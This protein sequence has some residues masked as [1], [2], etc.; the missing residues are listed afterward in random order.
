MPVERRSWTT[1]EKDMRTVIW[2][3]VVMA[4]LGGRAAAEG[5][6]E[7]MLS[8]DALL[9]GAE[10]PAGVSLA[11]TPPV[12]WVHLLGDLPTEN[13]KALWSS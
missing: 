12:V 4:C 10:A 8:G 6:R 5:A 2:A 9:K 3:T 7:V 11:K 13:A 1:V